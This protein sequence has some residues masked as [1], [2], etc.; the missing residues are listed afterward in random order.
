VVLQLTGETPRTH[1]IRA[2]LGFLS[3]RL[4]EA[5]FNGEADTIES[6]VGEHRGLLVEAE[7][8]Y[9]LARYSATSYTRAEADRLV[10]LSEKLIGMLK[11]RVVGVLGVDKA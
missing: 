2:L 11:D 8:A 3:R 6:F 7:E 10:D 5:G 1:G 4:R 9:I